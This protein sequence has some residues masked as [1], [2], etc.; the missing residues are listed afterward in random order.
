VS[1]PPNEFQFSFF[2]LRLMAK[3]PVAFMLAGAVCILIL[4]VAWRVAF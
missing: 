1:R 2:L 3:G 4:A